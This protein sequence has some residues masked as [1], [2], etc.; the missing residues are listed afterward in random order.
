LH[1]VPLC[2]Q[3]VAGSTIVQRSGGVEDDSC[4]SLNPSAAAVEL[5]KATSK[6]RKPS[7]PSSEGFL[8]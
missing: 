2:S 5:R 1:A 4:A 6:Q 8:F 7:G 3:L